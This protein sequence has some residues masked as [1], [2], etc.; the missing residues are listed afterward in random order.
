MSG[1]GRERQFVWDS[2]GQLHKV[3]SGEN[4][5]PLVVPLNESN[6]ALGTLDPPHHP[7]DRQARLEV[8]FGVN[9]DRWLIAT[10]KD[11]KTGKLL[12]DQETVVQLL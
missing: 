8:A 12:M 2:D 5:M 4:K 7:G 10:V 11:L 3:Q 1:F 9:D 6:P